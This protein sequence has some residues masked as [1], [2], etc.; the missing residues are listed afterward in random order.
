[1]K[2]KIKIAFD[3]ALIS[4]T[5][6]L[7][8]S[9]LCFSDF[10]AEREASFLEF[11]PWR[12]AYL[13]SIALFSLMFF[14]KWKFGTEFIQPQINSKSDN[15]I[16]KNIGIPIIAL[17]LGPIILLN[18][19]SYNNYCFTDSNQEILSGEFTIFTL[20]QELNIQTLIFVLTKKGSSN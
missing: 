16:L 5:L 18:F 6:S 19:Y 17:L 2:D 13:L 9:Y 11:I 7:L 3:I 15:E 8:F 20:K 14:L 10:I 12:Y 1:M 4:L